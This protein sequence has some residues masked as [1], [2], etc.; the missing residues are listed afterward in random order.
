MRIVIVF[1]ALMSL[2]ATAPAARA[3]YLTPF[4]HV[5]CAPE[6][7]YFSVRLEQMASR[8][9]PEGAQF[10]GIDEGVD[11]DRSGDFAVV[12]GGAQRASPHAPCTILRRR[13]SRLHS[14]CD[15]RRS[16]PP[17]MASAKG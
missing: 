12:R 5:E 2:I 7:S 10:I 1:A 3:D 16:R 15:A 11:L 17:A 9:R 4:I 8:P 6:Q 13:R 14:K